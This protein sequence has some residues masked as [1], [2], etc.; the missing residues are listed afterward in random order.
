MIYPLGNFAQLYED[1]ESDIPLDFYRYGGLYGYSK[2][3]ILQ[4]KFIF[5]VMIRGLPVAK[6][7]QFEEL[8]GKFSVMEWYT[9]D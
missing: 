1:R 8:H 9:T 3:Y 5:R 6:V 4:N 7:H 2:K